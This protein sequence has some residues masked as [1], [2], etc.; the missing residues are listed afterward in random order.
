[1]AEKVRTPGCSDPSGSSG[2]RV[3]A[4]CG[5]G[6][7]KLILFILA[8]VLVC[9]AMFLS[10][11]APYQYGIRVNKMISPRGVQKEIY[12]PGLHLVIPKMQE[13]YTLAS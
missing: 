8:L 11:V 1:M 6:G 9:Y 10:Y 7:F 12:S 5:A 3:S 13:M 4:C 2:Y